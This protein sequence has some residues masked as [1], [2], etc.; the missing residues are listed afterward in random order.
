M[1]P[2]ELFSPF[3][4]STFTVPEEEDRRRTFLVD[5][6]SLISDIVND[7]KIGLYLQDAEAFNGEKWFYDTT[8]K[9]RNGYQA[10]AR[11]T[12]FVTGDIPMPIPN[13][14][15]QFVI[16]LSYG[17]ASKPCSAVG[18]SDGDYFSFF[19]EGNTNIQFTMSDTIIHITAAGPMAD[20]SGFIVIHYLRS[21]D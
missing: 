8:K 18:A 3:L 15:E 6:L 1:N 7:K 20:Y 2:S 11:I 5:K 12:S 13:I 9:T 4:P 14:N 16:T 10:I 17:S 19:S 21:G